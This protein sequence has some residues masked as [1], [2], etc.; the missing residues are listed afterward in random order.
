MLKEATDRAKQKAVDAGA[1][2]EGCQVSTQYHHMCT[3][4]RRPVTEQNLGLQTANAVLHG[5]FKRPLLT[6]GDI[7]RLCACRYTP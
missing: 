4:H 7:I 1:A 3:T 6:I 5:D 2:P